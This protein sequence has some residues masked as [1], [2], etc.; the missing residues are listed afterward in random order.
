MENS[1]R[2]EGTKLKRFR[3]V[4]E[5]IEPVEVPAPE[6]MNED[7]ARPAELF[8]KTYKITPTD[9]VNSSLYITINNIVLNQGTEFEE[10]RPFEIFI[11]SKN[12]E[13]VQW[14]SALTRVMSAVFRKGGDLNFL[15]EELEEVFDPTGGYWLG[16][17]LMGSIVAH[18]GA[19][20]REHLALLQRMNNSDSNVSS[21]LFTE[22]TDT[23]ETSGTTTETS[24]FPAHATLCKKCKHKSVVQMDGC[25]TC[26][27][28]GDGKCS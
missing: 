23:T 28:C 14:V 3:L 22:A 12:V 5:L 8:G 13:H 24:Q 26:L 21:P 17:K 15:V 16:S 2:L 10:I 19:V 1:K 20:L 25:P 4:E 18:I 6:V 11:N 7:I 27:N 9:G